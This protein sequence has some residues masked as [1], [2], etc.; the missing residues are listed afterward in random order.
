MRVPPGQARAAWPELEQGV[1]DLALNGITAG[2][3]VTVSADK[4]GYTIS[5]GPKQAQVYT[6]GANTINVPFVGP[7]E[8]MISITKTVDNNLSI[9]RGGSIT[10]SIAE[11]FTSYEWFVGGSKVVEGGNVT[12]YAN[13]SAFVQGKN[14]ITVA[15]YEGSG[16][17]AVP[18][19]GEFEVRVIN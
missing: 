10:L 1:Y 4:S 12:L 14:W 16:A 8:R 15:V 5:G 2:G 3:T 7:A 17:N 19:S 11:S 13:N 6:L 18:W 9:T